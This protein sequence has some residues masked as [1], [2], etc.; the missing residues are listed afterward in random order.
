MTV[1]G[2]KVC[3]PGNPLGIMVFPCKTFGR[4]TVPARNFTSAQLSPARDL[5]SAQLCSVQLVSRATFSTRFSAQNF[6]APQCPSAQLFARNCAQLAYR[7]TFQART[8]YQVTCFLARNLAAR[9]FSSR[10]FRVRNFFARIFTCA[11]FTSTALQ[12]AKITHA[13]TCICKITHL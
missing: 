3:S 7:A 12:R 8:F 5:F 2:R 6:Y 4:A 1:F 10:D 11:T 9:D 13:M